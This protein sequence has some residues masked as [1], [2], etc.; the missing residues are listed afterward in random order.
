MGG[1]SLLPQAIAN[2]LPSGSIQLGYFLN[3][4]VANTDGTVTLTFANGKSVTADYVILSLPFAVLR[5]IDYSKAGFDALKTT[6]ITQYGAGKNVK[7]NMQFNSRIWYNT[8]SDGSLYTDL[9]VQSGWEVSRGQSG[10][11]GL[12]VAYPGAN[13]SASWGSQG[14]TP[15]QRPT[16]T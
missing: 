12:W 9:P 16:A 15:R 11:Q 6:A 4:I 5:T 10:T 8:V 13:V 2:A 7:L 14:R 3:A 1:N